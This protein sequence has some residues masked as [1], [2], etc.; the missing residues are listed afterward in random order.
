MP[1]SDLRRSAAL[2]RDDVTTAAERDVLG[3]M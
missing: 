3:S 1:T 2:I